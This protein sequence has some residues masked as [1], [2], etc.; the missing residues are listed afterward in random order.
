MQFST[1]NCFADI[2]PAGTRKPAVAIKKSGMARRKSKD[3][4]VPYERRYGAAIRLRADNADC[5]ERHSGIY[6]RADA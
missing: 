2:A 5:T 3:M 1:I 6:G 4:A